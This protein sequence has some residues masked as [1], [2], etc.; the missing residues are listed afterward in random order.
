MTD[1]E[2]QSWNYFCADYLGKILEGHIIL[3]RKEDFRKL[4]KKYGKAWINYLQS[5]Y[6]AWKQMVIIDSTIM[7]EQEFKEYNGIPDEYYQKL[8]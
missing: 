6:V 3:A 1:R 8:K 4:C 5:A 7:S 2:I